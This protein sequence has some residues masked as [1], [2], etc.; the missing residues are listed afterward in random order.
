MICFPHTLY[1]SYSCGYIQIYLYNILHKIV[2]TYAPLSLSVSV[3]LSQCLVHIYANT[4]FYLLFSL[5]LSRARILSLS[6]SLSHLL[7]SLSSFVLLECTHPWNRRRYVHRV[8]CQGSQGR[9]SCVQN[10]RVRA[11]CDGISQFYGQVLFQACDV[12]ACIC[13]WHV[14]ICVTGPAIERH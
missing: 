5:S 2:G 4:R 6:I 12:I 13:V 11:C 10:P 8:F 14:C 3:S 9:H 1:L 7:L